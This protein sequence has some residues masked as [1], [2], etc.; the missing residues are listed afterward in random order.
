MGRIV[1]IGERGEGRRRRKKRIDYLLRYTRDVSLAVVE[2]KRDYRLPA[3]GLQQAREYA[4]ILDLKFAY[5]TNGHGIIEFDFTAGVERESDRFSTP[6]ELWTRY[7]AARNLSDQR[8]AQRLLT[9]A[10]MTAGN[11]PRLSANRNTPRRADDPVR[12]TARPAT[13]ATGTGKTLAAFEVC[14]MLWSS[15]WN[16]AGEY[17]AAAPV[18]KGTGVKSLNGSLL[19]MS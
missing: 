8:A 15:R 1:P 3:D 5:S 2:A 13:I 18:S 16:C 4:E 14:W 17:I 19:L 9:P 11:E 12:K 7:C 6:T 10:D